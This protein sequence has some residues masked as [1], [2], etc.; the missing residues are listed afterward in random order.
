MR[1]KNL[2]LSNKK[3][4]LPHIGGQWAEKSFMLPFWN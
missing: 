2:S 1:V 4:Y 3:N